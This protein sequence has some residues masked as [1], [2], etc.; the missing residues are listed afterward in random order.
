M[1]RITFIA[2][3]FKNVWEPLSLGYLAAYIREH[4][5]IDTIIKHENFHETSDIIE[6]VKRSDYVAMTSTTPTFERC[7]VI[8]KNIRIVIPII[9]FFLFSIMFYIKK[10]YF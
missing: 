10:I 8:A 9:V 3:F 1:K 7:K 6:A 5:Y 4:S 2:P